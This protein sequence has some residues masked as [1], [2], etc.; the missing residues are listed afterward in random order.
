MIVQMVVKNIVEMEIEERELITQVEAGK[1]L[2][3][4]GEGVKSAMNRGVLP[5]VMIPGK[6]KKYTLRA[7]VEEIRT[8]KQ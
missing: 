8:N 5:E 7:N 2:G 3:M 6:K 4:T 1:M